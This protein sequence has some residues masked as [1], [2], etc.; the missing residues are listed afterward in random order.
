MT[1]MG[2]DRQ[3]KTNSSRHRPSLRPG[4][5]TWQGCEHGTDFTQGWWR[6]IR[7]L[8]IWQHAHTL[9][10][11]RHW[12]ILF[13]LSKL[14]IDGSELVKKTNVR[15]LKTM[16]FRGR[17]DKCEFYQVWGACSLLQAF[18]GCLSFQ[19]ECALHYQSLLNDNAFNVHTKFHL[20]W[21]SELLT[22]ANN[23]HLQE[24]MN[25]KIILFFRVPIPF[26]IND[27]F[28]KHGD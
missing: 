4:L 13:F 19:Y 24:R 9:L 1:V 11:Y 18:P 10:K 17:W 27:Y 7:T 14:G 12:N 28:S 2:L 15:I 20:V 6:N 22:T 21:Q 5:S 16:L 26:T 8:S 23:C 3:C 25:R